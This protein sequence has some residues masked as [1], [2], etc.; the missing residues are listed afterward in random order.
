MWLFLN[1]VSKIFSIE[2]SADVAV[3]FAIAVAFGVGVGVY[4]T[5]DE[6]V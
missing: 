2:L 5:D 1:L 6:A 3:A 4:E